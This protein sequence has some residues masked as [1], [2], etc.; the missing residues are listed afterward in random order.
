MLYPKCKTAR[1]IECTI[2]MQSQFRIMHWI[3]LA[4]SHMGT[5][6][7]LGKIMLFERCY[8]SRMCLKQDIFNEIEDNNI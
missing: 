3:A 6:N 1:V 4:F 2:Q 8:K 5:G 7:I